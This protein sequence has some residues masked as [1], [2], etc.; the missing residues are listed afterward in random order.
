MLHALVGLDLFE[1]SLY[2]HLLRRSRLEGQ[3]EVLVG[4]DALAR[5]AR[6]SGPTMRDRL[7]RLEQKGVLSLYGPPLRSCACCPR[8]P[9]GPSIPE[10]AIF[11]SAFRFYPPPSS[12]P[13][14]LSTT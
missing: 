8:P 12:P 14:S 2:Y 10:P 5:Q 13:L 1:R 3:R 11:P 6:L 9:S 7:H 4:M